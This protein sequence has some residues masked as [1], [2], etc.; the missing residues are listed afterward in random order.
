MVIDPLPLETAWRDAIVGSQPQV[1]RNFQDYA[2]LLGVLLG[3]VL[4]LWAGFM[5][6][7]TLY[8]E[9][10]YGPTKFAHLFTL[11]LLAVFGLLSFIQSRRRNEIWRPVLA[12]L[13]WLS[14][15]TDQSAAPADEACHEGQSSVFR[16][17]DR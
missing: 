13:P 5:S 9:N 3:V 10:A 17:R 11:T 2:G 1:R 14:P 7:A 4:T 12:L 6:A 8:V 16:S 15:V